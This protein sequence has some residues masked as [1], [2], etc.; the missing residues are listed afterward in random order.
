MRLTFSLRGFAD[1]LR[2]AVAIDARE[3]KSLR[4]AGTSREASQEEIARVVHLEAENKALK[5]ENEALRREIEMLRERIAKCRRRG[6]FC[7]NGY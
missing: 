6:F 3:L 5:T 4:S 1:L 2:L 7:A